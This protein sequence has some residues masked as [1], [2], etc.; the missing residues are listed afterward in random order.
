METHVCPWYIGY[1]L[2]NPLRRWMQNPNKIL[3]PLVQDGMAVLEVVPGMGFFTLP[4]A[5][6][7][8][9]RGR[10]YSVDVQEKM[11]QSLKRRAAKAGLTGR[12]ESR[13]CSGASLQ[14]GDLAG[15][16]DF[17]LAFAV[18]HEVPDQKKLF[19]EIRGSLKKN[20]RLLISEPDGRVTAEKFDETLALAAGEGFRVVERPSISRS[21]SAVLECV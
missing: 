10:I 15:K 3:T 1:F 16:I 17:A 14:I 2:I 9:E 20:G 4:L 21:Y 18:V 12:I 6:L 7:V 8:G 11:L 19:A 13:I 5:R